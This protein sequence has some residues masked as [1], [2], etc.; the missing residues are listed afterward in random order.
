[1]AESHLESM[2][3]KKEKNF[4]LSYGYSFLLA[5]TGIGEERSSLFFL[6]VDICISN[7]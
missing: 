1:M 3:K 2:K 4:Q 5:Q 6:I 7:I